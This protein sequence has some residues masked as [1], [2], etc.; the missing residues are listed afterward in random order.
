[1]AALLRVWY[2]TGASEAVDPAPVPEGLGG[3]RWSPASPPVSYAGVGEEGVFGVRV[4]Q[5]ARRHV[6][7]RA[8]MLRRVVQQEFLGNE[9]E[10]M[11]IHANP[12]PLVIVSLNCEDGEGIL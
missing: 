5:R 7:E 3:S 12:L 6:V 11:D 8:L 2:Y 1:M 4:E 9:R 10:M